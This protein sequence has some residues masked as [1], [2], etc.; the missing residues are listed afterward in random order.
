MVLETFVL[1]LESK[2]MRDVYG[3]LT[4]MECDANNEGFCF[5][6]LPEDPKD[7]VRAVLYIMDKCCVG[8]A[9][10]HE[11]PMVVDDVP[12]SYLIKQCS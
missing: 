6:K 5:Q 10:Y 1:T 2:E 11:M 4:E 7:T 8:D 3:K 12:R 9:A